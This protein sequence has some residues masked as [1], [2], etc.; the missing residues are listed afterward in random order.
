[1]PLVAFDPVEI[2]NLPD[3]CLRDGRPAAI[4]V[5]RT[6]RSP[7]RLPRW[8]RWPL[9]PHLFLVG[10][11]FR[12]RRRIALPVC[13]RCALAHRLGNT[14]F[15][16]A[17]LLTGVAPVATIMSAPDLEHISD[18]RAVT[19]VA[20][21]FGFWWLTFLTAAWR[22]RRPVPGEFNGH[23][24]RLRVS[25]EFERAFRASGTT[26]VASLFEWPADFAPGRAGATLPPPEADDVWTDVG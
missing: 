8:I 5:R 22:D 19:A 1:M 2:D 26:P 12:R 15:Y 14:V 24:V 13:A 25:A 6:Y 20:L 11:I 4:K 10:L 3:V 7:R 23:S 17:M 18:A 16:L 9:D 21:H